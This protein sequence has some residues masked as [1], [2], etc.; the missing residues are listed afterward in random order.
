MVERL[1]HLPVW[2]VYALLAYMPF[3]IFLA[4]SLSLA[5]GGLSIWKVAKDFLTIAVLLLSVG[6][7]LV[8]DRSTG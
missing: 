8:N 2:S 5:T 7:V 4:Q 3:H 6:L 1:K